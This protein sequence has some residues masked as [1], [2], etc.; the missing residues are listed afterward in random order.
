MGKIW[1]Y[2]DG[3]KSNRGY[4]SGYKP[5]PIAKQVSIL[6]QLFPELK[7]A[8]CDEKL[9]ERPLPPYTEGWFAIPRWQCIAKTYE[10][11]VKK[12]LALIGRQRKFYGWTRKGDFGPEKLIGP[13]QHKRTAKMLA[14]L[15][16]QQKDCDILVVA[17]QFGFYHRGHSVRRARAA[18]MTNEFGLGAFEVGCMLLTHPERLADWDDL[19]IRC[20]GDE[21][22]TDW[23]DGFPNASEF[24]FSSG[25]V[26][27][28]AN[29]I[30]D[31]DSH[32]G[33]ASGFLPAELIR[34]RA[35]KSRRA[36]PL[37]FSADRG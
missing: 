6:R 16:N 29:R 4:R 9:A 12:V 8:T 32:Y 2:P 14:R 28:D 34:P 20:A 25:G 24:G 35:R 5:R 37:P 36:L 21:C 26:R 7:D 1:F 19:R 3:Q 31:A 27:F 13:R 17:A 22:S 33:S 10:G 11:A 23:G 18:F 30:G 15:G